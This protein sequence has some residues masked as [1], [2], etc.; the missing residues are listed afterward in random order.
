MADRREVTLPGHGVVHGIFTD[1]SDGDVACRQGIGDSPELETRRRSLAP[2]PWTW[3][4]QV[5]GAEVV[6]VSTPGEGSG[7]DA[8]SAV[9]AVADA[10]LSV[11]VA[12][13]APVLMFAPS[14]AGV[15][16]A[17]AHAGWRG[18]L[19]GVLEATVQVMADLGGH[20]V[21]YWVGPCISPQAYEFSEVE[22][23]SLEDRFGDGVR[24]RTNDGKPALDMTSAVDAAMIRA[25]V[26][27][28]RL[29]DASTCTA[30]SESHWSHRAAGD[31]CRQ[32]GVIWWE[33]NRD[34]TAP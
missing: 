31:T 18:L 30:G 20:D 3:L 21:S 16:V 12:D 32:A 10:T 4:H 24:G 26:S 14:E 22:L 1:R 11:Q 6:T 17:A 34:E 15:V 2:V 19:G 25:G 8:D 29:G 27:G 7:S 28:G 9:S 5:H 33:H 23:R 13:C